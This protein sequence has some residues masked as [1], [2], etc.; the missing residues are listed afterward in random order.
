[1]FQQEEIPSMRFL[2]VHPYP[3]QHLMSEENKSD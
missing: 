1:M 3:N 2:K